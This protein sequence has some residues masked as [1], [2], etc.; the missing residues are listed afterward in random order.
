MDYKTYKKK[1]EFFITEYFKKYPVASEFS[2]QFIGKM[3]DSWTEIGTFIGDGEQGN[4]HFDSDG[5]IRGSASFWIMIGFLSEMILNSIAKH[6]MSSKEFKDF[7][8][9]LLNETKKTARRTA[10]E[11]AIESLKLQVEF[12]PL[13]CPECGHLN[14]PESNFCNKCGCG[15]DKE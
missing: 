4:F 2:A 3:Q 14:P 8:N 12:S 15:F 9:E 13:E 6:T 11:T 10:E 1:Y 7:Q 5:K